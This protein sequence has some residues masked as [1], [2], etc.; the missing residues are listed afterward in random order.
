MHDCP[1][2]H[3]NMIHDE[4]HHIDTASRIPLIGDHA[5][6]FTANTTNGTVNFPGDYA[7]RWVI[8]FSHPAD[9]TPVCTTEFM[10]FQSMLED[11]HHLNTYLI[12]LS[13]GT[14]TGHLAW[15]NAIRN[16]EWNG[17]K[18]M[19]ITFPIID[20]MSMEIAIKYGMIQPHSSNTATVRAVFIIDPNGLVRTILY[21]PP[22]VGRNLS[23][24]KRAL[25]ALQTSDAFHVAT[26]ANWVPGDDVV[27]PAPS[28][29][30]DLENRIDGKD[31]DLDVRAWFLAFKHLPTD[32]ILK[33][34][35]TR[36]ISDK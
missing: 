20:D 28:N 15:L 10:A 25:I 30:R 26:P 13:V 34:L 11:F 23:E 21:Y 33:K 32:M 1:C 29:M 27:E 22:S 24:I 31:K 6:E 9:F 7:G 36:K 5:P 18:D 8:L 12:G 14:L 16:L 35:G 17:W 3:N 19:K 2:H 4:N